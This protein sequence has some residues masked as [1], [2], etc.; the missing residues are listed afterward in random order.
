MGIFFCRHQVQD[1]R[2]N[3]PPPNLT[4]RQSAATLSICVEVRRHVRSWISSKPVAATQ[5][6]CD[7]KEVRQSTFM[8]H[9]ESRTKSP[10]HAQRFTANRQATIQH[11]A[12]SPLT[13]SEFRCVRN[14]KN[15]LSNLPREA[16]EF[17]DLPKTCHLL[18]STAI[19]EPQNRYARCNRFI[20]TLA[21]RAYASP[22]GPWA[23]RCRDVT[24]CTTFLKRVGAHSCFLGFPQSGPLHSRLKTKPA[25]GASPFFPLWIKR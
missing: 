14:L 5:Q 9:W 23:E 6:T 7:A 21:P 17:G 8:R 18:P 10:I 12:R 13:E 24:Q 11:H 4:N 16:R 3:R 2:K 15:S 25:A 22:P 1:L 19:L 20:P